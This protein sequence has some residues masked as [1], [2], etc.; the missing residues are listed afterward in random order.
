[1]ELVVLEFLTAQRDWKFTLIQIL[2]N[3]KW[4]LDEA[5]IYSIVNF[6]LKYIPFIYI[7]SLAYSAC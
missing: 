4:F 6:N 3:K 5:E 2:N 7:T 1:M